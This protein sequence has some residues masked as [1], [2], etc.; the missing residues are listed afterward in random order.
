MYAGANGRYVL[1]TRILAHCP[2]ALV[3]SNSVAVGSIEEIE[4]A[5]NST[6]PLE[7]SIES[8]ADAKA[9]PLVDAILKNPSPKSATTVPCAS[10]VALSP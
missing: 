1:A 9:T 5:K 3:G 7:S 2:S 10:N 8:A 4:D 6:S